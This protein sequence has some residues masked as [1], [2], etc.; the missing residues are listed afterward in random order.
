MEK[1]NSAILVEYGLILA[2]V[3]V[4]AVTIL[5]RFST[6]NKADAAK[7]TTTS[8]NTT[9]STLESYCQS[10]NKVYDETKNICK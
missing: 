4:V 2:L 10:I 7:A 9:A 6:L 5:G 8:Q 3:A 1:K